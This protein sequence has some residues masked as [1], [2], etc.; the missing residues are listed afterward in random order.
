MWFLATESPMNAS[1]FPWTNSRNVLGSNLG[2]SHLSGFHLQFRKSTSFLPWWKQFFEVGI[3]VQLEFVYWDPCRSGIQWPLNKSQFKI[4][5]SSPK[6]PKNQKS[7]SHNFYGEKRR[8]IQF[9]LKGRIRRF[10]QGHVWTWPLKGLENRG[11]RVWIWQLPQE[12]TRRKERASPCWG[13]SLFCY[14]D[15]IYLGKKKKTSC[16]ISPCN[17]K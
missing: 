9:T 16:F 17:N 3:V 7:E 2:R 10:D 12:K 4:S 1:I 15:V 14:S 5:S 13:I 6:I 11:W 8:R